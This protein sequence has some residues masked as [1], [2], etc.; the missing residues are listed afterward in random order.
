VS[1]GTA[2]NTEGRGTVPS[3]TGVVRSAVEDARI[4][5]A[6]GR[7]SGVRSATRKPT[8]KPN[9]TAG[10]ASAVPATMTIA[11]AAR[12][13]SEARGIAWILTA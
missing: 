7:S 3:V 9:V 10:T 2:D 1:P 12:T 8:S 11:N 4:A 5:R 13:Q 6:S